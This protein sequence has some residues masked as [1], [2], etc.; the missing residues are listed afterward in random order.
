MDDAAWDWDIVAERIHYSVRWKANPAQS[1]VAF[2][3]DPRAYWRRIHPDDRERVKVQLI[4]HLR[5]QADYFA[6]E[7]R[8]QC[9]N[10][11]YRWILTRGLASFN[12]DGKP[13]RMGGS[14]T[15]ITKRKEI[16]ES[17]RLSEAC[18]TAVLD[19]ALDPII[20]MDQ[21]GSIIRFNP[22][23][24]RSFGYRAKDVIGKSAVTLLT[25]VDA[26][27]KHQQLL[28]RLSLRH[29]EAG[30][31]AQRLELRALRAD[32]SEFPVELTITAT[33]VRGAT[34]LIESVRDITERKQAEAVLLESEARLRLAADAAEIGA[35]DWDVVTDTLTCS[36][37]SMV[38][39]GL[40]PNAQINCALFYSRLHPEDRQRVEAAGF[41]ALS[42]RGTGEYAIDARCVRA[43]GNVRWI[44]ARGRAFFETRGGRRRPRRLIGIVRD[45]TERKQKEV[46]LK[47]LNVELR[48]LS[49][50]LQLAR[51]AERARIARELHDQI[52]QNLTATTLHLEAMLA[53][54]D[55]PIS[56]RLKE[57]GDI[58]GETL[59]TVRNLSLELR[60]PQL[61]SSGLTASLRWMLDRQAKASGLSMELSADSSLGRLPRDLEIACF[62]VAQESVTNAVRHAG[63]TR[64]SVELRKHGARLHLVVRDDG[65]GFDVAAASTE[66][67]R[68]STFGLVS[69]RERV[70][71]AGGHFE[72]RSSSGRGTEV[73]AMFHIDAVTEGN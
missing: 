47:R 61:D 66:A 51:E 29:G 14:H 35:W 23:A 62:R 36:D 50:H 72:L 45:I 67:L 15:D 18:N 22:A 32:G 1:D 20:T 38:L 30:D 39:F 33:D 27:G 56:L 63:A 3:D 49:T 26:Q 16:E 55:G 46:E 13:Y 59:T 52:G 43:D 57:C 41:A 48:G 5:G 31:R 60:P 44:S 69:M 8:L 34:L 40:A 6:C 25:P 71:Y 73:H 12:A 28:A 65:C 37:R 58:I 24:E 11:S 17:L 9:N 54:A 4:A 42:P 7:Y 68:G 2:S 53:S 21:Y 70:R 10:D 64:L 19:S